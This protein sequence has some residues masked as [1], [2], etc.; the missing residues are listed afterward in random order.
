MKN[1]LLAVALMA[2]FLL[3]G[4]QQSGWKVFS[5]FEGAFSILMP[6]TFT[7]E[8]N[9]INT[10]AGFIDL[11][12]FSVEQEN[13]VYGVSY[14]DYPET[15]VQASTPDVILEGACHGMVAGIGGKLLTE[16]TMSLNGYPGR[17]LIIEVAGGKGIVQARIFLVGHRLYQVMVVTSLEDV[18]KFLDSFVV[19]E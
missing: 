17:E 13:D 6:G 9:V 11:H 12:R 14:S 4:S 5:S 3:T 1:K 2:V 19:F 7:E 10:V 16:S 18:K 8:I 15:V